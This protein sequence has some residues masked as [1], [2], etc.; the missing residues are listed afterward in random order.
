MNFTNLTECLD[1]FKDEATGLAYLEQQRWGGTPACPF[2]GVINPYRTNR[3]FKCRDK[4]CGKKFSVKVGT[5]YENS[6]IPLR[7]WFT[8][9]YLLLSSKKGISSLQLSR[10]LGITQKTAW[11]VLH[12]LREML[13]EK[14][15]QMLRNTV[16]IDETYVGGKI[17]NKHKSKV[18]KVRL[19]QGGK[20]LRGRSD[21]KTPVFGIIETGGKVV[22]KV[23]DWVNKKNAKAL[24]DKHVKEGA[25]MVTG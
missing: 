25:N 16:Q 19:E 8:S 1:Y 22:V 17:T 2:C 6:K 7:T 20:G 9:M 18:A 12:R 21:T 5:I 14:A 23:T 4:A 13:K 10:Q 15:P 11:F 24:I 3:G